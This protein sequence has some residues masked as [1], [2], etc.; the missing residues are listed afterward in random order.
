MGLEGEKGGERAERTHR[1]VRLLEEDL[2]REGVGAGEEGE[3]PVLW[4]EI[5]AR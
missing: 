5:S 2:E 1:V 4:Y 3:D